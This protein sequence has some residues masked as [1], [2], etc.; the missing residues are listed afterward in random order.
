MPLHFE[1][2]KANKNNVPMSGSLPVY[3]LFKLHCIWP[4][5]C[6]NLSLN[7]VLGG[8][9]FYYTFKYKVQS[10]GFKGLKIKLVTFPLLKQ[11]FPSF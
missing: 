11:V 7:T 1:C 3:I 9:V 2:K 10:T 8:A 4:W 5:Y 6:M